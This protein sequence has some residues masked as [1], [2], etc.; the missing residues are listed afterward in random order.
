MEEE[1]EEVVVY[2]SGFGRCGIVMYSLWKERKTYWKYMTVHVA[3]M[4][5]FH[6]PVMGRP[7]SNQSH[8]I[9]VPIYTAITARCWGHKNIIIQLGI[10]HMPKEENGECQIWEYLLTC[11][12]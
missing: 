12:F 5:R 9:K 7:V 1:E 8:D 4:G 6:L 2:Q 11:D 3:N 10:S